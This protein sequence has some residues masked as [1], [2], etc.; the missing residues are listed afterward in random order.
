MQRYDSALG[1]QIGEASKMINETS[2]WTKLLKNKEEYNRCCIPIL[3]IK[4]N[5]KKVSD[6]CEE[7]VREAERN[8]E[9]KTMRPEINKQ[10]RN[11]PNIQKRKRQWNSRQ[12][13]ENR[14]YWKHGGEDCD[15]CW[16][17][18]PESA[19]S[20][21]TSD[22]RSKAQQCLDQPCRNTRDCT[23]KHWW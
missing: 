8:L 13:T 20:Y 10:K 1:R 15:F 22:N 12:E 21:W 16:I 19:Y 23:H 11:I 2:K 6:D 7:I 9:K 4:Y 17:W 14:N 18:K 3:I 5:P